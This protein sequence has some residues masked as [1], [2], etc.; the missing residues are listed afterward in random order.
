METEDQNV[1]LN[2]DFDG[3]SKEYPIGSDKYTLEIKN[4]EELKFICYNSNSSKNEKFEN[5][6]S[7]NKLQDLHEK[8][9][10]YNSTKDI[11]SYINSLDQKGKIILKKKKRKF[12]NSIFL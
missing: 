4:G 7:L 6:L 10:E 2:K 5:Q 9:K 8:L 12:S 11:F 3:I 1:N